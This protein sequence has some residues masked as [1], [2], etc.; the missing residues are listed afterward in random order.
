MVFLESLDV[1]LDRPR[2]FP[3]VFDREEMAD[4]LT[5]IFGLTR[6]PKRRIPFLRDFGVG[7]HLNS[8]RRS[9]DFAGVVGGF[10]TLPFISAER[11]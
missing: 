3:R 9:G 4:D 1:R 5:V 10:G 2:D 6:Q 7:H 11:P 8:L